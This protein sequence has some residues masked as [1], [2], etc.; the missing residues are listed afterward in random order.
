MSEAPVCTPGERWVSPERFRGCAD[1]A[2][3]VDCRPFTH[4]RLLIVV[5]IVLS[6]W[7]LI[8]TQP[9]FCGMNRRIAIWPRSNSTQG[10]RRCV[11]TSTLLCR[12]YYFR[13]LALSAQ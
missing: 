12:D 4:Q 13:T 1:H 10:N 8:R 11:K 6:S 7:H 3:W 2:V 9:M 5:L